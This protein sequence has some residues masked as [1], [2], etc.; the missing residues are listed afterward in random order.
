MPRFDFFLNKK[1]ISVEL[2]K[3]LDVTLRSLIFR[4][5]DLYPMNIVPPAKG[6]N[7][8]SKS[9]RS[10]KVSLWKSERDVRGNAVPSLR[11][12][13]APQ[14]TASIKVR[15]NE[16]VKKAAGNR[17]KITLN[18]GT[19]NLPLLALPIPAVTCPSIAPETITTGP[20]EETNL[21][22]FL[23]DVVL[24]EGERRGAEDAPHIQLSVPPSTDSQRDN[25][26]HPNPA[27]RLMWAD[28]EGA[29]RRCNFLDP[30]S[31]NAHYPT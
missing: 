3:R 21:V 11:R 6:I 14:H 25:T 24:H 1:I 20:P 30:E 2:Q 13:S 27:D 7:A 26:P 17:A 18:V 5:S 22:H 29:L 8:L 19:A 31:I 23:A 15:E 16:E 4:R 10:G 9:N 12:C 28:R